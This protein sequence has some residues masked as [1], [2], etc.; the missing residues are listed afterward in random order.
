[1]TAQNYLGKSFGNL[2]TNYWW[3]GLNNPFSPSTWM[4]NEISQMHGTSDDISSSIKWLSSSRTESKKRSSKQVIQDM[5]NDSRTFYDECLTDNNYT[6]SSNKRKISQICALA[7]M[8]KWQ[9]EDDN[10]WDRQLWIQPDT[11]WSMYNSAKDII[12]KYYETHDDDYTYEQFQKFVNSDEDPYDFGIRMWLLLSPEDQRKQYSMRELETILWKWNVPSFLS[13]IHRWGTDSVWSLSEFMGLLRNWELNADTSVWENEDSDEAPVVWAIENYAIRNFWKHIDELDEWELRRA[14]KDLQD[15]ESFEKFAPSWWKAVTKMA[16]WI[17]WWVLTTLFPIP[18]AVFWWVWSTGPWAELLWWINKYGF[19]PLWQIITYTNPLLWAF[20]YNLPTDD[21]VEWY[22]FLWQMSLAAKTRKNSS[23]SEWGWWF[24]DAA[25]WGIVPMDLIKKWRNNRKETALAERQTKLKQKESSTLKQLNEVS[26]KIINVDTIP[27]N[28][29]ITKALLQLDKES[30]KQVKEFEDLFKLEE[31][32]SKTIEWQQ[33]ALAE[34][35]DKTWWPEE[36]VWDVNLSS[37]DWKYIWEAE[38]NTPIKDFIN[39]MEIM[40]KDGTPTQK[41]AVNIIKQKYNDGN[42]TPQDLFNFKRLLSRQF[43]L[44]TDWAEW[45]QLVVTKSDIETIRQWLNYLLRKELDWVPEF[46]ELWISNILEY[47]DAMWSPVLDLRKN[48][49]DLVNDVNQLKWQ[50]P[51][52]AWKAK[53]WENAW[54]ITSVKWLVSVFLKRLSWEWKEMKN[55]LDFQ[56]NLRT[57][58]KQFTKLMNQLP[59]DASKNIENALVEYVTRKWSWPKEVYGWKVEWEVIEP[60]FFDDYVDWENERYRNKY[61]EDYVQVVEPDAPWF[62]TLEWNPAYNWEPSPTIRVTPEWYAWRQWQIIESYRQ[63]LKEAW[64]SEKQI[65][66]A[67]ETLEKNDYKLSS[68]KSLFEIDWMP[69]ADTANEI[70]KNNK[71]NNKK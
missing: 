68:Q 65:E 56:N 33:N 44:Y 21:R 47:S 67:I 28:E 54:K 13:D 59:E 16:E 17:W 39:K 36:D 53:V 8:I 6:S 14:L 51:K 2:N 57:H 45:K 32:R 34:T 5:L 50:I 35:I 31:E 10:A 30:L 18:A 11:D 55:A 1:M 61:L 48:L 19:A 58:L 46:Q 69:D 71:K 63:M 64:F 29:R 12:E 26:E 62:N 42:I 41:K 9:W 37:L 20:A 4:W 24:S 7:S 15:E 27:E 52:G 49:I 43:Q 38:A 40:T 3:V 70:I 60:W 23:I 66:K 22:E 25:L